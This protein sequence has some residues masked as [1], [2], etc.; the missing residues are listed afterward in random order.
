M[1]KIMNKLQI[2]TKH[3]KINEANTFM[4]IAVSASVVAVVFSL[5]ATQ[6]LVKQ[7]NYQNKVISK[8]NAAKKQLDANIAATTQ[9]MNYYEA[10]D[11]AAD[12]MIGTKDK[13]SKITLD[14]LPSKYDFPALATSLESLLKG[15]GSN[16]SGISGSDNEVAAEQSSA[17]PKPI[18]IP[19]SLSSTGSLTA[20]QK[21]ITDLGR[22]IRPIRI[23]SLQLTGTD[24]S[25]QASITAKTYYQP[26]K[27]FDLKYEIVKENDKAKAVVTT[28]KVTTK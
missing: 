6:A 14:A 17:N 25:M 11:S 8:R 3:V 28:K 19:F 27:Q 10:F 16:I 5:V 1:T 4:L 23:N 9:L 2:S 20:A 12:S 21:L 22:S 7:M 15:S 13:N 18:E 26:A 24:S